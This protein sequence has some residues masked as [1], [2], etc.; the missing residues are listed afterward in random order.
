MTNS[1]GYHELNTFLIIHFLCDFIS[2]IFGKF[3]FLYDYDYCY[4]L[5]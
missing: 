4:Y 3:Y 1:D 2:I 5:V